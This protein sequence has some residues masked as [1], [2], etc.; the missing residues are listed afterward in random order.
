VPRRIIVTAVLAVMGIAVGYGGTS[1]AAWRTSSTAALDPIV[2][3]TFGLDQV[4]GKKSCTTLSAYVG[5]NLVADD[6]ANPG[7]NTAMDPVCG[8]NTRQVYREQ[9]SVSADADAQQVS[10]MVVKLAVFANPGAEQSLGAD[11][12]THTV[13]LLSPAGINLGTFNI[14]AITTPDK[15]PGYDKETQTVAS[16]TGYPVTWSLGANPAGTYTIEWTFHTTC[17]P[18]HPEKTRLNLPDRQWLLKQVSG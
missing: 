14:S 9:L 18:W 13:T 8:P 6:S 15:A 4:C 12:D 3:G 10:N 2:A 11:V 5:T 16:L 17:D 1:M 7:V